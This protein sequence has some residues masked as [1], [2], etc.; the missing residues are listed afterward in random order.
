MLQDLKTWGAA[1]LGLGGASGRGR[2]SPSGLHHFSIVR[3]ES[4]PGNKV[5]VFLAGGV[6][7]RVE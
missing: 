7:S 3:M 1:A 4:G 5:S 2:I 6:S